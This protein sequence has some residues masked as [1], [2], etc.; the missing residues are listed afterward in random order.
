MTT[1]VIHIISSHHLYFLA[2][3]HLRIDFL[4]FS[5]I[6]RLTYIA[7]TVFHLQTQ[8]VLLS[9][10]PCETYIYT[11]LSTSFSTLFF[12]HPFLLS[13]FSFFILFLPHLFPFLFISISLIFPYLI[14]SLLPI[15]LFFPSFTHS[16][17]S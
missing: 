6:I 15:S 17:S 16:L 14:F 5:I 3:H 13:I 1:L 8:E 11:S 2:T 7:I 12:P 10:K 4:L 9:N